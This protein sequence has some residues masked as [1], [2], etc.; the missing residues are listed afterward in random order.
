[1]EKNI[2]AYI[3]CIFLLFISVQTNA[4]DIKDTVLSFNGIDNYVEITNDTLNTNQFTIEFWAR[5]KNNNDFNNVISQ[6]VQQT[7]KGL[8][9]GFLNDGRFSFGFYNNSLIS[10][11][12]HYDETWHHWAC[13]YE[14]TGGNLF[15]RTIYLDGVV[16]TQDEKAESYTGTGNLSIGQ[17]HWNTRNFNGLI[18]EVRIWNISRTLTDIVATRDTPLNGNE[19]GLIAYF[20][21]DEN[22]GIIANSNANNITATIHGASWTQR[23]LY[24]YSQLISEKTLNPGQSFDYSFQLTNNGWADDTYDISILNGNWNYVISDP[25]AKTNITSINVNS[26]ATKD[27][28]VTVTVPETGIANG[29]AETVTVKT[30]SQNDNQY[31]QTLQ[32]VTQIPTFTFDLSA[33]DNQRI[34]HPGKSKN[35]S[36]QIINN[37][38]TTDSYAIAVSGGNWTYTI[39]NSSN[40]SVISS[41]TVGSNGRGIFNVHVEAPSTGITNNQT[42]PVN[43]QVTSQNMASVNQQA[44]LTTTVQ[45]HSFEL[46]KL[47]SDAYGTLGQTCIYNYQLANTGPNEDTFDFSITGEKKWNYEIKDNTKANITTLTVSGEQRKEFYVYVIIPTTGVNNGETDTVNIV[48]TSQGDPSV[49]KQSQIITTSPF[50]DVSILEPSSPPIVVNGKTTNFFVQ[51]KNLGLYLDKYEASIITSGNWAYEIRNPN[52]TESLTS[53]P[54]MGGGIESFIVKATVP[55][56]LPIGSTDQ[57]TLQVDSLISPLSTDTLQ[58]TTQIPTFDMIISQIPVQA[59]VAPSNTFNY[60]VYIKNTCIIDDTYTLTTSSGNWSYTLRNRTNTADINTIAVAGYY[61]ETFIL[62]VGLPG[63]DS[64]TNGQKDV[65]NINAISMGNSRV[66]NA[67]PI[68]TASASYAF[69][70]SPTTDNDL[71]YPGI[72]FLHK[73]EITNI[74]DATDTYQISVQ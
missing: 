5:P 44:P 51:L 29:A 7:N 3:V 1:M 52:D 24:E 2:R 4:Q 55:Y 13:V 8:S 69:D 67:F 38:L 57:F 16:L 50:Y 6:G 21:F 61:S 17:T 37:G 22:S 66:S 32:I 74:G 19:T 25:V 12:T 36:I 30:I 15:A 58:F 64:I 48:G 70:L 63:I 28:Y 40:A 18:D 62:Q 65:V 47:T 27:F 23:N 10:T 46:M 41:M 42:D 11:T 45:T 20:N 54:V 71:V 9:I 26:G 68:T 34:V 14:N 73:V 33:T 59:I 60:S 43:L 53:L 39:M 72:P 31:A 35:Y 49:T 56:D